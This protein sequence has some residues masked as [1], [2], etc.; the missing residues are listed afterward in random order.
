MPRLE[1]VTAESE[2]DPDLIGALGIDANGPEAAL[3]RLTEVRWP[4][5]PGE[6]FCRW[7][8][9][10][11]HPMATAPASNHQPKHLTWEEQYQ[12]ASRRSNGQDGDVPLLW[13]VRRSRTF[14]DRSSR[15]AAST[16][17][18]VPR[19]RDDLGVPARI[20]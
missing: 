2:P 19:L 8:L 3:D 4:R 10:L 7:P 5:I 13:E 12:R 1:V 11:R 14:G 15:F 6:V 18:S 16:Q 20:E 9:C 17:G